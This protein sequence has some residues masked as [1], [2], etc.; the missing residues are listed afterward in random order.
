MSRSRSPPTRSVPASRSLPATSAARAC[1]CNN[2][3]WPRSCAHATSVQLRGRIAT[4]TI[5]SGEPIIRRELRTR[6][7]KAGLRAMSIPIDPSRAVGGRLAA[8]DRIDVLFAGDHEV[9]II[10]ARRRGDRDRRQRP[11]RHRRDQQPVHGH[12]RG[13][14]AAIAV[15]RGRD[16]RRRHL[17][18]AH[19][20]SA[21]VAGNRTA[22]RS[23]GSARPPAAAR[24]ERA[25]NP[26]SRS[27]SPRSSGSN[28][29]IGTSPTTAAPA[30]ARSCSSRRSR[31][32]T[33]T[34]R[35]S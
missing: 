31:W 30:S 13:R 10:V 35:S 16:R 33:S 34:T 28:D 19:D 6:A 5:E 17:A 12:D 21:V 3:S 7:A 4:V 20:G 24:S 15:A 11:R 22:G 29:C 32:K 25:W 26:R 2:A 14:R 18:R 1:R 9:S 8:G 23:T 27:S